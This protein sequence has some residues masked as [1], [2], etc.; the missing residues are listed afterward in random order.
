[1]FLLESAFIGVLGGVI[2]LI[3]SLLLSAGLNATLGAAAGGGPGMEMKISVIPI[4][5]AISSVGFAALIGTLAGV[6][7]AQRA[8]R[9][10]PLA[11]IRSE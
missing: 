5:L 1:M 7:P 4:W 2:S 9:L 3:L 6:M 11:A 8:M 10:S